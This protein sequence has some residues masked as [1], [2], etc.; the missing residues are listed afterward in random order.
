MNTE[1]TNLFFKKFHKEKENGS[2]NWE[3]IFAAHVSGK[4]LVCGIDKS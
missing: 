4:E 1:I 2:P 3:K